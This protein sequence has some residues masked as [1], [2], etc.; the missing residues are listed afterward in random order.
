[1]QEHGI[2]VVRDL[3]GVGRNLQ[4]H[5]IAVSI[6]AAARPN[7]FD[8]E[9]RLDRIAWNVLKW[10]LTGKGTPAQS[11]LTVQG[12]VKSGPEQERPDLQFQVS[13]TSYM[14]KVWFPGWRTGAGH[15]LTAGCV[16]LDPESRGA[17]TLGSSDPLALPRVLLNFLA[18]PG[19]R[20]RLRASMRLMRAFFATPA[21]SA[22]VAS[23]IAP[24]AQ[25]STDEALDGWL[26]R[27]VISAGHPACTCAMGTGPDAV[28]DDGLQVRGIDGLRVADA[29]SM[30]K[31]IRGNTNAPVIMIAEKA[32]DLILEDRRRG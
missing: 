1:L 23:E 30:P 16:L 26:E 32:A 13:H 10:T 22:T 24:G 11:P 6:W 3:P 12:F 18:Q 17:V 29:A 31:L 28:L 7:T 8:R 4:D 5:P 14:A 19:D 9:L 21:A 25:A 27:T 2:A 15:Q 20:E